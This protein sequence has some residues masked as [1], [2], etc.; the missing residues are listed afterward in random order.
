MKNSLLTGAIAIALSASP[1]F[2]ADLKF[3]PGEDGRFTWTNYDELKKHNF[4]GETVTIAGRWLAEDKEMV[5]SVF[6]YFEKATGATIK[7]SGSESF[8]QQIMIDVLAGSPPNIGI[9]AQPGLVASLASKG[10]LTPLDPTTGDWVKENYAAGPSWVDLGTFTDETGA[11]QLFSFI[12]KVEVKSLVWYIPDNFEDAGYEVPKTMEELKALTEQI[13][14]DGDT[15]WCVGIG[16]GAA[17]GWPATDWV[18]DLMLRTQTPEDYDKW[19]TN[20]LKF[21]DKKVIEAIEDYGWFTRN[22]D[23]VYGGANS[24]PATDFRDSA[25]GMFASPPQCYLHRQASFVTSF[26][27]DGTEVGDDVDFFYFPAYESKDLGTPVLGGGALWTI[28]KDSEATRA[29]MA[30]LK[31]P[32]AHEVWMA[33][34]GFLTPHKN[35]NIET[36]SNDTLKKQGQL[37]LNATTF[38]FDGSDTM[39]GKIGTG[40]FW[41]GMVDYGAGKSAQDVANEIQK[42]WDTLE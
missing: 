1:A 18:E 40:A 6:A 24:V 27:P 12:Y 28:T 19:T 20:E 16:S 11:E 31:S 41:T 5:E 8:E 37:L 22:D 38:R 21:N 10:A 36:Y 17:T 26:F 7:Y 9:F 14:K 35:A 15:P 23:F 33:Q 42:A 29:F 2:A 3:T 30:F 32:L 25:K 13:A 4:Q 39:P 34:T